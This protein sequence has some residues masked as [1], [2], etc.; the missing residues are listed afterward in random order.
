GRGGGGGREAGERA[1]RG[2]EGGAM[3]ER[4]FHDAPEAALFVSIAIGYLIGKIKIGFFQLGSV[5]G[6]LLAAVVVGQMSVTIS[7][8]VKAVCFGLFIFSVGYKSGPQFFASLNRASTKPILL[9][10]VVCVTGLLGVYFAAK[11]FGLDV[12]T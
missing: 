3:I 8:Q 6:T 12:G 5:A 7:P 4:L 9:S 11:I 1:G 2:R 10:I